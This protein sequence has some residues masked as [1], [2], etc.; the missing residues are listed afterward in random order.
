MAENA[1]AT[2]VPTSLRGFYAGFSSR[3]AAFLTD[4][5]IIGVSVIMASWF[6]RVINQMLQIKAIFSNLP[7]LKNLTPILAKLPIGSLAV[8]LFVI[9]Y[10]V[11]FWTI[12]GQTPGKALFGIRVIPIHGKKLSIGRSLLRYAGYLVSTAGLFI[13]FAWILIDDRRQGWH[14]KIAGTY[15]VYNWNARPD[16]RFLVEE[17]LNAG[18]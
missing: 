6:M 2:N 14:D 12:I 4:V 15:V 3:L 7:Y 17:I 16:E 11:F 5:F 18:K 8:L 10:F 13:G 9:G 1:K